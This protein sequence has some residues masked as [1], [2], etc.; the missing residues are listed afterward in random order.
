[1]KHEEIM[2]IYWEN[3]WNVRYDLNGC[4]YWEYTEDELN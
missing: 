3:P 1:V 2:G 4:I